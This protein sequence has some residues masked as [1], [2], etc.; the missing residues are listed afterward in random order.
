MNLNLMYITNNPVIAKIAEKSGVDWIF[1]DLEINGKEERQGHLDTVISRHKISDV[2]KIKGALTKSKLVVRVNPIFEGSQTEIKRVIDDGADIIMLPYFKCKDEVDTFVKYVDK[3]AK[4]M[5][6]LETP[7]AVEN[8]DDILNV[9]GIDYIHIGLNDLH[10]GYGMKFMFELLA[11]GTVERL[12]NKFKSVGIPYGFGGIAQLGKG[13]L[14][15]EK[16][17]TEHYRLGSSMVILSR[18]FC[19]IDLHDN[20]EFIDNIFHK[21]VKAI[22]EFEKD[23]ILKNKE[24]LMENKI[25]VI[26][27]VTEI[28]NSQSKYLVKK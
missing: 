23:N 5:L 13:E 10:L 12:C 6:L 16:I 3:R 19:N 4:T 9:N 22:R 11:D 28:Q 7:E 2:N 17:I 26:R 1:L 24:Y 15:A 14:P 27:K 21:G 8:I 18:S 20:L 25:A